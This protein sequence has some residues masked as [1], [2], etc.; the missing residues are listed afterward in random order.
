LLNE[1]QFGAFFSAFNQTSGSQS[2]IKEVYSIMPYLTDSQI[3]I[4]MDAIY[5]AKK[6]DLP[7]I[8]AYMEELVSYKKTNR[9]LGFL[10]SVKQFMKFS[11]LDEKVR[12][13][14]IQQTNGESQ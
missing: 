6:W 9:S 4:Y 10:P 13:V 2:G 3:K 7:E 14:K 8:T 1:D 12:N 5:F 11:T